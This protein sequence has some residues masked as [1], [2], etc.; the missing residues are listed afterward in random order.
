MS[1]ESIEADDRVWFERHFL[2]R[3]SYIPLGINFGYKKIP[4]SGEDE[5]MF[6]FEAVSVFSKWSFRL[7]DFE[8]LINKAAWN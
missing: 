3:R 4:T 7:A 8:S 1:L 5:E 2:G 6:A